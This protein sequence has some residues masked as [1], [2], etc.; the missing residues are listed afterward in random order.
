M[1]RPTLS[2]AIFKEHTI[3]HHKTWFPSCDASPLE[4]KES[5]INLRFEFRVL[6]LFCVFALP[7]SLFYFVGTIYN[8]ILPLVWALVVWFAWSEIHEEMHFPKGR[9]FSRTRVFKFL[10]AW[11][12]LHHKH[13]SK[14]LG[15]ICI[16]ADYLLGTAKTPSKDCLR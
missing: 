7:F 3:D 11:H 9:W 12:C 13:Q 6:F 2:Y 4:T 5:R 15:I 8:A 14:N 1:H 10:H 16:G